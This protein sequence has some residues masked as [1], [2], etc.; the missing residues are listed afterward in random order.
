[1][2][3][4]KP[5]WNETKAHFGDWWARRGLVLTTEGFPAARPHEVVPAPTCAAGG[6]D[7]HRYLY[8]APQWRAQ[9]NHH[10]LANQEHLADTLPLASIDIGPGSLALICTRHRLVRT[11]DA[12]RRT[13][14]RSSTAGIRPG[15][16]LV[17]DAR[18]YGACLR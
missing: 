7:D 12:G 17:A 16:R 3:T 8:T 13:A 6:V 1:M 15:K 5:N 11:H 10:S 9:V 14:G 4:W 18:R 2:M